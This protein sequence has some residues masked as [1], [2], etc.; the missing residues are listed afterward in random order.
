L[1]IPNAGTIFEVIRKILE[2]SWIIKFLRVQ[3][4]LH[5][6]ILCSIMTRY[7]PRCNSPFT[8]SWGEWDDSKHR[9]NL[10]SNEKDCEKPLKHQIPFLQGKLHHGSA[11]CAV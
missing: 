1:I 3:G 6:G 8:A 10:L 9:N 5:H 2:T 7:V 11:P 4:E